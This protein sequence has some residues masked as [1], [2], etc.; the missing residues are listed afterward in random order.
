M[1]ALSAVCINSLSLNLGLHCNMSTTSLSL[2]H[3]LSTCARVIGISPGSFIPFAGNPGFTLSPFVCYSL[4]IFRYSSLLLVTPLGL[5]AEACLQTVPQRRDRREERGVR[6]TSHRR[7]RAYLLRTPECRQ[8]PKCYEYLGLYV[9]LLSSRKCF[10]ARQAKGIVR[11]CRC[12]VVY[13]SFQHRCSF[14]LQYKEGINVVLVSRRGCGA[15]LPQM[16]RGGYLLLKRASTEG[17]AHC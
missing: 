9:R 11:V 15:R 12:H 14:P 6:E 10:F 4:Q 17:R 8:L 16:K 1:K 5:V 3:S 13:T 2:P 7:C